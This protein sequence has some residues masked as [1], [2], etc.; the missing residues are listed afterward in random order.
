MINHAR[1][2]LLNTAIVGA[3]GGEY[4]SP[5]Y[6]PVTLSPGLQTLWDTLFSKNPAGWNY[7]ARQLMTILHSTSMSK[8]VYELDPRITYI[9]TQDD[10][11]YCDEY[12]DLVPL[13]LLLATVEHI[14]AIEIELI[15]GNTNTEI[16]DCWRNHLIPEYRLAALLMLFIRKVKDLHEV[17]RC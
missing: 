1:T 4:S 16:I 10:H 6:V 8:Y 11:C 14:P 7:R 3:L 9:Q 13:N 15:P 2:L 17:E 5:D 12:A